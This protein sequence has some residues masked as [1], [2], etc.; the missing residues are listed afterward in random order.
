MGKEAVLFLLTLLQRCGW[1]LRV[2][3]EGRGGG[4]ALG[5]GRHG[6]GQRGRGALLPHQF[7]GSLVWRGAGGGCMGWCHCIG[8]SRHCVAGLVLHGTLAPAQLHTG[9]CP[10]LSRGPGRGCPLQRHSHTPPA[11]FHSARRRPL[12]GP[13]PC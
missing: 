6:L 4:G 5:P 8:W 9:Q 10:Q 12:L 11:K 13:Y 3:G 7:H 1:L 2:P